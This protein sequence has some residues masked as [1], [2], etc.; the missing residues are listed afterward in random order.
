MALIPVRMLIAIILPGE[1]TSSQEKMS[2]SLRTCTQMG[3]R[4]GRQV[5]PEDR[6]DE[7]SR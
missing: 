2:R 7:I 5:E 1:S 4:E 3:W 6:A